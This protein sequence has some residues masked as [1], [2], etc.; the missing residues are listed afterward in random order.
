MTTVQTNFQTLG[1]AIH[2]CRME[3]GFSHRQLADRCGVK[4]SLIKNWEHDQSRPDGIPWKRLCGAA[5]P[6]S[7]LRELKHLPS[8]RPGSMEAA[9]LGTQRR[10]RVTEA[11]DGG[12]TFHD[13]LRALRL[14]EGVD[15]EEVAEL[16]GVTSQAVSAWENGH[17]VPVR[18]HYDKLLALLPGLADAPTP[19]TQEIPPPSGG[20]GIS[21]NSG[22]R[23]VV[24]VPQHRRLSPRRDA[25]PQPVV[26]QPAPPRVPTPDERVAEAG[27]HYASSLLRAQTLAAEIDAAKE[28]LD[29]M[30]RAHVHATKEV[31]RRAAQLE[32]VV[33][34]AARPT[35]ASPEKA[36][37][38]GT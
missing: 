24:D 12:H 31:T 4:K 6:F 9:T 36:R 33:K 28:R 10:R 29:Q 32:E 5:T 14:S 3:S 16:L 17:A 20:E 26:V 7:K 23:G 22:P 37:R 34:S 15:Q 1:E 18:E 8:P 38:S 30:Q 27:L 35:P 21:R 13:A 19:P 11:R 2:A 25:P